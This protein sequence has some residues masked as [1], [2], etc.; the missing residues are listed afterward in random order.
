MAGEHQLA[1][2]ILESAIDTARGDESINEEAF[3][4]ALTYQLIEYYRKQRSVDDIISEL[5]GHI[6][7]LGEDGDHFVTRGC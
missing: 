5:E 2:R 1:Q 6:T 3:S 7:S 4:R